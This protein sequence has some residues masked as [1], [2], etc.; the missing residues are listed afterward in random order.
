ME[1]FFLIS[2]KNERSKPFYFWSVSLFENTGT[3][4]TATNVREYVGFVVIF[5][6]R[7]VTKRKVAWYATESFEYSYSNTTKVALTFTKACK[8]K[9]SEDFPVP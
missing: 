8:N 5:E 4:S 6:K 9:A 1:I 2:K 3:L 7:V